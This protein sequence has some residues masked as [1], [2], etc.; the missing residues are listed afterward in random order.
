MAT[1][2]KI[3]NLV[4]FIVATARERGFDRLSTIHI[5]KYIYIADLFNAKS[6]GRTLT[7][8]K[9][10]FWDFGPWTLESYRAV[11]DAVSRGSISSETRESKYNRLDEANEYQLF[12]CD[13]D[14]FGDEELETLGR[15]TI[16]N[17]RT[18][19][20]L[21]G[22]IGE[23]G[24]RI[25]PLLH[26]V[27]STEP[28]HGKKHGDHLCF[29]GLAWPETEEAK[30]VPIKKKRL[31]K[32]KEIMKRIKE[33]TPP[34]YSPPPGKFDDVYYSEMAM[35]EGDGSGTADGKGR[36]EGIACVKDIN[37]AN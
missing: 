22:I 35:L 8:W 34:A 21:R 1:G 10:K 17:A 29:D 9:W 13:R 12:Y 26:Y 7:P 31:K 18:C 36:L 27:Y 20:A 24:N 3:L 23:Y 5:V 30:T 11:G 6:E 16:P 14:D 25:N 4:R 15:I 33:R 19:T 37:L 28:L 32:A 2:E